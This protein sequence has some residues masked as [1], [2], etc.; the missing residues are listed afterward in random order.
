VND[1]LSAVDRTGDGRAGGPRVTR[2]NVEVGLRADVSLVVT[3]ADTAIALS[4]GSVPVLATPRVVGL[5]EEA[6]VLAVE[7]ALEPGTTTV[8][9]QV[10]LE[11]LSPTPVGG[12]VRA[13]A[14][15]E[16]IN[17]RRI[18]FTVQVNDERGLVAVGRV[19]RVIVDPERFLEK[20]R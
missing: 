3:D 2:V 7:D 18:V 4:G 17:G 8:G 15:V 9:M 13:E 20:V 6:A 5:V 16:K 12:K 14:T 19:T 11:H 10:Q 1:N